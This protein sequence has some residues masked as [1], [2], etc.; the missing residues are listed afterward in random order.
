MYFSNRLLYF[1]L[2][3]IFKKPATEPNKPVVQPVNH[4]PRT[5]PVWS[6]VRFLKLCTGVEDAI[7]HCQF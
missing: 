6:P 7:P 2:I 1:V 3:F 4:E 5:S